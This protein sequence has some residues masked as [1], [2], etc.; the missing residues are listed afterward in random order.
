MSKMNKAKIIDKYAV[1]V[2]DVKHM[3]EVSGSYLSFV[4]CEPPK[5]KGC[6]SLIPYYEEDNGV[7][8]QRWEVIPNDPI[9]VRQQIEVLK[10]QLAASDYKVMKC[11][12]ASL[13][14]KELPYDMVVLHEERQGVRDRIGELEGMKL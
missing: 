9:V 2:I 8:Y 7:V 12:E 13:V 4:E 14:G 3:S 1:D 5:V 6:G 11:Y 10:A